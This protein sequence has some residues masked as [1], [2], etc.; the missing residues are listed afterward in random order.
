M[1]GAMKQYERCVGKIAIDRS[2]LR[3]RDLR[4]LDYLVEKY[5]E[6][7]PHVKNFVESLQICQYFPP[8]SSFDHWLTQA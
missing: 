2:K 4:E 6:D 8:G 7:D 1:G 3:N 5:G